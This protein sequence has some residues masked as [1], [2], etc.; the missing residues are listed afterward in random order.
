V[1]LTL[2]IDR[3]GWIESLSR[4]NPTFPIQEAVHYEVIATDWIVGVVTTSKPVVLSI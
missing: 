3:S 1:G 4:E 2:K